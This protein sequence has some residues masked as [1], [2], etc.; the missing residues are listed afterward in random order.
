MELRRKRYKKSKSILIFLLLLLFGC[1]DDI[2]IN[3]PI[4]IEKKQVTKSKISEKQ[5]AP[6]LF[7]DLQP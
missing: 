6:E 5:K 1:N 3:K 7:I 4:K 2:K